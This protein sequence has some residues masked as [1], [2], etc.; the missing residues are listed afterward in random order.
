MKNSRTTWLLLATLALVVAPLVIPGLGG[1]FKGSDD[2]GTDAINELRPDYKPWFEPLWKPPSDEIESLLFSL[3]AGLGAGFIGFMIGRR[4]AA[5]KGS[6]KQVSGAVANG[7]VGD[8][9]V[10]H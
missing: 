8:V 1:S 4:S 5:A 7:A 2:Q 6:A 3:Q 9:N 10:A